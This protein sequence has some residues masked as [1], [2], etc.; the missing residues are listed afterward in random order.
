METKPFIALDGEG[1]TRNGQHYYTLLTA[2]DGNYIENWKDG[3]STQDCLSFVASF[4]GSGILVGFSVNYD[5]N[6]MLRDLDLSSLKTLWEYGECEWEGW[7]IRWQQSK[8][9]WLHN[10][11]TKQ[12]A[13]LYDVFGFFQKSFIRSLEDWKFE[14]PKE[15]TEG[16]ANRSTFKKSEQAKIRKYNLIECELLVQLMNKVR[17]AMIEADALPAHWHGAG[18]IATSLFQKYKVKEHNAQPNALLPLFARA[19]FG[20]RNQILLQG[21]IDKVWCH[22]INSAYPYAM[23]QL[24]TSIGE[25]YETD[26]FLEEHPYALYYVEWNLNKKDLLTPFPFRHKR[27]IHWPQVGSGWYWYPEVKEALKVYGTRKIRVGFG[28]LFRPSSDY[29]PFGFL[30]ELYEQRKQFIIQGSDAQLILKLGINACY[31]KVAQS[32]GYKGAR[33]AYQN[34]FWAG[35]ITS[36]CRAMVFGVAAQNPE[37]VCSFATDGVV[38][39]KKLAEHSQ[40]KQLGCW[41]VLPAEDFFNIQ[42]GVYCFKG[43]GGKEKIRTRGFSP[44]SVD[45][46]ELRSIWRKDGV[47]GEYHYQE[48]RFIGLGNSLR[49]NPPLANWGNWVTQDRKIDFMPKVHVDLKPAKCVRV[50][51]IRKVSEVSEEYEL[52]GEWFEGIEG[53]EHLGD[54]EQ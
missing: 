49:S 2:S 31:G 23:A 27:A 20:G 12:S 36:V 53:L 46:N 40:D 29:K 15:I 18:A 39:T 45:Y 16:K 51:P 33:P 25:W 43:E 17:E 32:I 47:L 26:S 5:I 41:E 50:H 19:Y 22:D 6:K 10:K 38:A 44:R 34:Y 28:Y 37:S 52:K 4:A 54:L 35:Y 13:T 9:L 3:L 21:E 24:P 8:S 7:L 11:T 30:P 48:T 42:S 14:V 1:V